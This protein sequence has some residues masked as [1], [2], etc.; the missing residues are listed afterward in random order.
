VSPG[1]VAAGSLSRLLPGD[2]RLLRRVL[3][4]LR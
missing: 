3:R 1:P 2:L 4:V